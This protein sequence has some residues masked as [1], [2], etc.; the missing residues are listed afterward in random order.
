MLS[1]FFTQTVQVETFTG[2]GPTGDEFAAAV[3]VVGLVDDGAV[4]QLNTPSGDVIEARAAFFCS[5]SEAAKF[6]EQSRVTLPSG[7]PT[8][9]VG[10]YRR[11]AS[12]VFGEVEHL[13]VRLR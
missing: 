5:L 6:P 8:Q 13:E 12:P 3:P 11:E 4:M 2:P 7:R 10:A 9:V 1:F